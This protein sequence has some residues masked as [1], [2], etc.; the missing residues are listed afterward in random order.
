MKSE[1]NETV[2]SDRYKC[3]ICRVSFQTYYKFSL[4]NKNF[5]KFHNL[6]D[7]K[8]WIPKRGRPKGKTKIKKIRRRRGRTGAYSCN[9][10]DESN[11]IGDIPLTDE[12]IKENNY[13]LRQVFLS[14]RRNSEGK[15]E[16]KICNRLSGHKYNFIDH[17]R[18]HTGEY[19]AQCEACNR[20]FTKMQNYR[21]HMNRHAANSANGG[22]SLDLSMLENIEDNTCKICDRTFKWVSF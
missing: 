17:L 7:D 14:H 21:D 10:D 13:T 3:T 20:N 1:N 19:V 9:S 8:S 12:I 18:K 4:H 16:C 15:Y 22:G 11:G 6:H 2:N 5:R